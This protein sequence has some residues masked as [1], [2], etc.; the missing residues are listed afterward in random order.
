MSKKVKAKTKVKKGSVYIQTTNGVYPY[1]VLQKAAIQK[2]SAQLKSNKKWFSENDLIPPPYPPESFLLLLESNSIFWRC[3]HQ[4]ASDVAGLG[5]SLQLKENKKESKDELKKLNEFLLKPNAEQSLRNIFKQL[6]ID[7]G[8]IGYF[9]IEVVRNISGDVAEIYHVPAHTLKVHE[10]QEK[11]AQVRGTKKVWFK[12]FGLEGN[13][14]LKDGHES[15]TSSKKTKA[16]E[17]IFY[18]NHYPKSDYY[19]APNILAA[20]GDVIGLIGLRDYNLAFFENYGVPSAIITLEGEW[21]TGSEKTVS[22]FLNKELKGSEKA[23]RT[24]V[25]KQPENCKFKYAPLVTETKEGAFKIY[26]TMRREDILIAYAMP[27]ERVGIRVVGKLGGNVA[28]EATKIYV[29]SVVEPLQTDLEEIINSKLIKSEI[30]DFKFTNIDLRDYTALVERLVKEIG[31]GL[32]TPNEARNELGLK[33]YTEGD[34]FYI[35][36]SLLEVGATEDDST[37]TKLEKE[38]L[39]DNG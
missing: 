7:W 32:R 37:L 30:Y 3:V 22:D 4:L 39:D 1:K 35:T 27:P 28:E 13:I 16:N 9:G 24:L 31:V 8:A 18:K 21:D 2:D 20:I 34:K 29:Q 23:H 26:E 19:G 6:L 38:F 10:S 11:Y 33:P 14:S 15:K 17:L 5:W 12:K 25:V 36:N